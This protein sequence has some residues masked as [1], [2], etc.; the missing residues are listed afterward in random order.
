MAED[1]D[2]LSLRDGQTKNS[3]LSFSVELL[4]IQL[5]PT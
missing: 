3:W 2:K 1:M 4:S 5:S